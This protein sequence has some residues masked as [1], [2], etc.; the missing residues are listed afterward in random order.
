MNSNAVTTSTHSVVAKR[1]VSYLLIGMLAFTAALGVEEYLANADGLTVFFWLMSLLALGS[2]WLRLVL[3]EHDY[4][5]GSSSLGF[6][7]NYLMS[8]YA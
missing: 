8:D 7:A 5:E 4:L 6:R 2:Y 3:I 1:V